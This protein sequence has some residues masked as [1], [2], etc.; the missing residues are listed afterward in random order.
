M[1]V[2]KP[3][4]TSMMQH[5][6]SVEV[7][8]HCPLPHTLALC[9]KCRWQQ[10]LS[11]H[12]ADAHRQI[13]AL[14]QQARQAAAQLERKAAELASAKASM[15][16]VQ[17]ALATLL[18]ATTGDIPAT[19]L[20]TSSSS[21]VSPSKPSKFAAA[22]AAAMGASGRDAS[23]PS[24][25]RSPG[26]VTLGALARARSGTLLGSP[27]SSRLQMAGEL[28]SPRSRRRA[29]SPWDAA[30]SPPGAAVG[31]VPA[32][33]QPLLQQLGVWVGSSRQQLGELRREQ[34][35]LQRDVQQLQQG[36]QERSQDVDHLAGGHTQPWEPGMTA[37][38]ISEQ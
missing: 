37:W 8:A 18:Q 22:V 6:T 24:S 26:R 2:L 20:A 34:Q 14:Q 38:H 23:T 4:S 35:A 32:E 12:Q 17:Q 25:P 19:G 13:T 5:G 21:P 29:G 7:S 10:A 27:R 36:L 16:A 33:M 28:E 1:E 30:E 31:H 15:A 11:A 9:T 3:W